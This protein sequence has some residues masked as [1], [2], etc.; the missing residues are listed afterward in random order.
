[1]SAEAV[2]NARVVKF[3]SQ[4]EIFG[5]SEKHQLWE[6]LKKTGDVVAKYFAGKQ[7]PLDDLANEVGTAFLQNHLGRNNV[8]HIGMVKAINSVR[9]MKE[10]PKI[11]KALVDTDQRNYLW[12]TVLWD[13]AEKAT[14]TL[15]PD[16]QNLRNPPRGTAPVWLRASQ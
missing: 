5:Y 2:S 16:G 11:Q 9:S 7:F 6:L 10:D 15:Q 14:F 3:P 12:A 8:T 13:C 4:Q 1:M